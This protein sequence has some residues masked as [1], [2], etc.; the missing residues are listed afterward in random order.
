MAVR[1]AF[2]NAVASTAAIT[3]AIGANPGQASLGGSTSKNATAGV[4]AFSNL[5]ISQAGSGYTLT[6][7]SSGLSPATSASTYTLT[8]LFPYPASRYGFFHPSW[9]NEGQPNPEPWHWESH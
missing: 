7:T 3:I 8:N 1:D 6:A 5:T 4:A 2:G 9:A